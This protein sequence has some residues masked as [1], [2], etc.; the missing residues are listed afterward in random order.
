LQTYFFFD[1]HPPTPKK[2]KKKKATE[3]EGKNEES[4]WLGSGD[5][6]EGHLLIW[7][8]FKKDQNKKDLCFHNFLLGCLSTLFAAPPP[9]KKTS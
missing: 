9:P 8:D 3:K 6:L 7:C 5:S 4:C 2:E 1:N